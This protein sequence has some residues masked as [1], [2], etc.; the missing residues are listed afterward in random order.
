MPIVK[1][2]FFPA[3]GNLLPDI[4]CD[5]IYLISIINLDL[6][7][8]Y[9]WF[10]IHPVSMR[11]TNHLVNSD[12]E[13]VHLPFEQEKNKGYLLPGEENFMSLK[14]FTL[15]TEYHHSC[16]VLNSWLQILETVSSWISHTDVL[17]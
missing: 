10:A 14:S 9:S 2:T 5:S 7:V 11:N 12:N 3:G 8:L 17:A 15:I 16:S 6:L 4:T 13:V 1:S